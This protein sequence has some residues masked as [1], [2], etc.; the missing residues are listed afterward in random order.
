MVF[1]SLQANAGIVDPT[2]KFHH[3]RFLS[4]S[5]FTY[6]HIIDAIQCK[7]QSLYTP[8]RHL[9]GEEV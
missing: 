3:N 6:H 1:L 7:K 9:G 2:L 5:T 4:N 8:W